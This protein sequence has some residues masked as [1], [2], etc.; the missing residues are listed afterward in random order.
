MAERRSEEIAASFEID[1]EG[2]P[3]LILGW[4]PAMRRLAGG[5]V[6]LRDDVFGSLKQVPEE[7]RARLASSRARPYQPTAEL[8][9]GEEHFLIPIG[10]LPSPPRRHRRRTRADGPV[11]AATGTVD[12]DEASLGG[13]ASDASATLPQVADLVALTRRVDDLESIDAGRLAEGSF[14]FYGIVLPGPAGNVAFIRRIDPVAVLRK[15]RAFF[16]YADA[17]TAVRRPDFMLYPDVDL[18]IGPTAIAAFRR[19]ALDQLLSDVRL[20]L[21]DVPANVGA[22]QSSLASKVP[23]TPAARHALE[24]YCSTRPSLAARLRTLPARIEQIDL[25]PDLLRKVLERHGED[26]SLL[27]NMAGEFDFTGEQVRAFLDV[28]ESRW[29]EDEFSG[30]LRRADRYSI[31]RPSRRGPSGP[32]L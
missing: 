21:Q 30:E 27:V 3:R 14:L 6:R 13:A 1:V 26:S 31:R 16:Q 9:E 24:E 20:V 4:R 10:D 11:S 12:G 19:S 32:S 23:L 29:F 28:A 2:D 22:V 7:A 18:I 5:R 8:E 15:G 25:T 17:L